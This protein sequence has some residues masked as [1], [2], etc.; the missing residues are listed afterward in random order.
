VWQAVSDRAFGDLCVCVRCGIRPES[1]SVSLYWASWAP[2]WKLLVEEQIASTLVSASYL[3]GCKSAVSAR[4]WSACGYHLWRVSNGIGCGERG[5]IPPTQN[6][7]VVESQPAHIV[8]VAVTVRFGT[9]ALQSTRR[10]PLPPN[11]KGWWGPS[12]RALIGLLDPRVGERWGAVSFSCG[13]LNGPVSL[14]RA[15]RFS[16]FSDY[17]P[18]EWAG[19]FFEKFECWWWLLLL[20][21][22]EK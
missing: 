9:L 8:L 2:V 3:V 1:V 16:F 17:Q 5:M 11:R 22:L 15:A 4:N 14:G 20:S 10:H 19:E 13:P 21:L 6:Y 18:T 7:G 12:L